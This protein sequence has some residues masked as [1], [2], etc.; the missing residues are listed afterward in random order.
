MHL[1]KLNIAGNG[2]INI[3]NFICKIIEKCVTLLNGRT[4]KV[5]GRFKGVIKCH[6]H[7]M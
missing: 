2:V 7:E 6:F 5:T 4:V 1:N 3:L